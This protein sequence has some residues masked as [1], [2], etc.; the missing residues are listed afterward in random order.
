MIEKAMTIGDVQMQSLQ[1]E[2]VL[3]TASD[4]VSP[5]TATKNCSLCPNFT[6]F[7]I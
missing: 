7:R 6:I 1:E 3:E 5:E 4:N 2:Q